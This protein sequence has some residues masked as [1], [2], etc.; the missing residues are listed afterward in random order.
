MIRMAMRL[1]LYKLMRRPLLPA[2]VIFG[3]FMLKGLILLAARVQALGGIENG[4][5]FIGTSASYTLFLSTF[6]L[7]ILA[8]ST[9][10]GE[11]SGGLLRMHLPRPFSRGVYF[12]NRALYLICWALFLIVID[13]ASG[14]LVGG[15]AFGFDDV[16]DVALQGP[17][18]SAQAMAGLV[19]RAYLLTFAGM[20]GVTALGL[21]FST[22]FR[23]PT[24]S[25]G[26]AAGA[27]F[28]MEGIRLVF[29]APVAEYVITRYT[30]FHMD[31]VTAMARGIA[32][33]SAP[34]L[35][36]KSVGIPLAYVA[37][38]VGLSHLLFVKRDILE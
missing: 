35:A 3:I 17:Q 21:F 16:A 5:A 15:W 24:A 19:A 11:Y 10:S 13:A 33:Y 1:E 4:F 7:C 20:A 25:L 38:L 28:F 14:V 12:A 26:A 36:L 18:F 34:D 23:T 31:H 37:L 29:R 22:L 30:S 2:G 8:S 6:L 27:F 9:I 32:E